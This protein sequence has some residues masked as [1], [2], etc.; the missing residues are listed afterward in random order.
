MIYYHFGGKEE[1]FNQSLRAAMHNF[2]EHIFHV[3]PDA[4][5]RRFRQSAGVLPF[6]IS[7]DSGIR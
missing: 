2:S 1:L 5:A 6:F 3:R 7:A 4:N